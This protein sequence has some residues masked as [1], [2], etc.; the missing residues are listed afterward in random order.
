MAGGYWV[1]LV[2][3]RAFTP[4]LSSPALQLATFDYENLQSQSAAIFPT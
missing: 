1:D 2:G 4:Q 3:E